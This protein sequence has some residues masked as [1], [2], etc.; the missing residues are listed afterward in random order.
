LTRRLTSLLPVRG[1]RS[2]EIAW[3]FAVAALA[4]G[5]GGVSGAAGAVSPA[6][7]PQADLQGKFIAAPRTL[8][9]GTKGTFKFRMRNAGPDLAAMAEALITVPGGMQYIHAIGGVCTYGQAGPNALDCRYGNLAPGRSGIIRFTLKARKLGR[10]R[11]KGFAG[12]S[13]PADPKLGNNTAKVV[14]RVQQ[15]P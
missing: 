10:Q 14:V 1:P 6:R 8:P 11:V 12:D 9:L 2:L 5:A 15:R 7:A 3:V 13:A 4:A